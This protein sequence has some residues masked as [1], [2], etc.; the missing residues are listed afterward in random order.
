[1]PARNAPPTANTSRITKASPDPIPPDENA[2]A[3]NAA[4]WTTRTDA[5]RIFETV[6]RSARGGGGFR[7]FVKF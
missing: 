2:I 3:I 5:I 4:R 6:M 7:L 1:M